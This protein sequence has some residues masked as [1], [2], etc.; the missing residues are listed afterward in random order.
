MNLSCSCRHKSSCHL[1]LVSRWRRFQTKIYPTSKSWLHQWR[2][3]EED[4]R[5]IK[6]TRCPLSTLF[7]LL[8]NVKDDSQRLHIKLHHGYE[9]LLMPLV[10][11]VLCVLLSKFCGAFLIRASVTRFFEMFVSQ[12]GD[13]P[14]K[15]RPIVLSDNV[16]TLKPFPKLEIC[17]SKQIWYLRISTSKPILYLT[18]K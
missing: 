1:S 3:T 13:I 14:P 2:K 4:C 16:S 18:I 6:A 9:K 11:L 12:I 15:T 7:Y 10:A 17:T 5:F 8:C